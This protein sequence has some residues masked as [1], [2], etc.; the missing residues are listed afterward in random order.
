LSIDPPAVLISV[1]DRG[2]GI[3]PEL[4]DKLFTPFFSTKPYGTGIGLSLCLSIVEA[5]GGRLEALD[6]PGG[7]AIFQF[8]IPVAAAILRPSEP[9]APAQSVER[10]AGEPK[11]AVASSAPPGEKSGKNLGK[12]S[13]RL[14]V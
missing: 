4:R 2:H 10:A 12:K 1:A 11:P 9:Q 3:P 5:H 13:R 14:A 7:G 6:N 8:S